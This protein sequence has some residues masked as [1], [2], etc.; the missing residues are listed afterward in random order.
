MA[1]FEVGE[2]VVQDVRSTRAAREVYDP[3]AFRLNSRAEAT[4]L[5]SEYF[6]RIG[7]STIF[8]LATAASTTRTERTSFSCEY[9]STTAF[10][11]VAPWI[12]R[13]V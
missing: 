3:S 7:A 13:L 1:R 6:G 5:S 11:H 10:E 2:E 4:A 8:D 9:H 12:E